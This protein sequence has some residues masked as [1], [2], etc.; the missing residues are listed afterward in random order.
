MTPDVEERR[1]TARAELRAMTGDDGQARLVG[2]AIVFGARSDDLG[3]FVEVIAPEAIKRT[4]R[5]NLD[6][7]AL[8]D[9]DPSRVLGRLSAGTLRVYPKRSGLDIEVDVPDTQYGRDLV[10]SVGRGDISGMSFA[11]KTLTDAWQMR[12]GTA[13]RTVLD[14]VVREVSVV[15]FPAYPQTDLT[16]AKRGLDLFLGK[17][18]PDGVRPGIEWYRRRQRQ[19]AAG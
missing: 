11:F 8:I 3:G 14:M 12:D 18:G 13:V 16:V 1:T 19:A 5:D 15:A 9:H 10:V 6:L 17:P 4:L 7:R 2:T